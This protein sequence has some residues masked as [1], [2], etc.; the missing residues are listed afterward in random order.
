MPKENPE[1]ILDAVCV[2]LPDGSTIWSKGCKDDVAVFQVKMPAA[3]YDTVP[4]SQRP[5]SII[6]TTDDDYR[7][8]K[9]A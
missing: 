3:M 1:E 8:E 5:A 9:A 2:L 6:K 7:K 4:T